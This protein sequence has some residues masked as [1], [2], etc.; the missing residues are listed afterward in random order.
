MRRR[1][2]RY[3]AVVLAAG[4]VATVLIAWASALLVDLGTAR[5]GGV[6][7][8]GMSGGVF[9]GGSQNGQWVSGDTR[10]SVDIARSA[11]GT[12]V[13]SFRQR[14][15]DW[16]P[17]QATGKP[18]T[19]LMG[20]IVTAWASATPDGQTE[21]L[22][23]E[24]ETSLTP[25]AIHVYESYN[26]GAVTQATLYGDDGTR[27]VIAAGSATT[28]A[29]AAT[30]SSVPVPGSGTP[31][32]V[33]RIPITGARLR[34]RRI[35][36][37]LDSPSVAGWNEIDA[38]GLEDSSRQMHWAKRAR[39]SSTYASGAHA[40]SG[41]GVTRLLPGWSRLDEPT[42]EFRDEK[43]N[44]E[45]RT[46]EGRGWPMVALTANV[47][48]ASD[49]PVLPL[50]PAISGFAVDVAFFAAAA[51]LLWWLGT[52]PARFIRESMHLRR[53][54][55]MRCGYELQYNFAAGCPECGWR[56]E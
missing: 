6:L 20:D 18:D 42:P 36:L 29:A 10:W 23:L 49:T 48:A 51:A 27:R 46:V 54:R 35:R 53:G 31:A 55:C 15:L 7:I 56:R 38:V 17:T 1:T 30:R 8:G 21:W 24:Y 37:D 32:R 13:T 16:G 52:F 5:G 26:P 14:G 39:A 40:P 45:R 33:L 25:V 41:D 47:P 3:L 9:G 4:V 2:L 43:I 28:R 22:E 34:T 44:S 11:T 12:R 50:R 19:P